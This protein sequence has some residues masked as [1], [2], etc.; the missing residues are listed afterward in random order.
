M[1]Y[2]TMAARNLRKNSRRSLA[3]LAAIAV[4]YLAINLF[5]G[6]ISQVYA[7]IKEGAIRG[8]GLGHLTIAKRGFFKAGSLHPDR[9]LF[10]QQE[11]KDLQTQL[12]KEKAVDFISPQLSASGL[13]SNGKISTIFIA[14]GESPTTSNLFLGPGASRPPLDANQP[15]AGIVSQGLADM[16]GSKPGETLVTL[17]STMSG[18]TNALDLDVLAIWD[19]RMT[20]TNDKTLKLPLEYVQKLLDTD[21]V[22]RVVV[23]LKGDTDADKARMALLPQL[24]NAGFDVEIQTWIERSSFYRQ[25]KNLF[26]LIFFFLTSIVSIVALMSIVNTLSMSVMERVREIGTL[27]AL[28]LQRGGIIR[29]FAI[30]GG[31][32]GL[33]GSVVGAASTLLVATVINAENLKYL[34]PSSSSP[35]PLRVAFLPGVMLSCFAA[36]AAVAMLAAFWPARRAAHVEIVDALGHV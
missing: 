4:G 30:E 34:P 12:Q 15:N 20:A 2:L 1:M 31:L 9:Y 22:S 18:Q 8:E 24:K 19:T 35:V 16:L 33:A 3:T 13:I 7:G 28:G 21:G 5:S 36:L 27:R 32:L 25:V 11:L 17:G 14:D 6:Y 10:N 29:L 23:M 26:D